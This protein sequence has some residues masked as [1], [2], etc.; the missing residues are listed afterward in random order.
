MAKYTDFPFG[1]YGGVNKKL[2]PDQLPNDT[3]VTMQNFLLRSTGP[4]T[5]PGWSLFTAQKFTDGGATPVTSTILRIAQFFKTDGTIQLVMWTN[6][7]VYKYLSTT[8]LWIPITTASSTTT[9]NGSSSSGQPTLNVTSSASFNVGEEVLINLGN[10]TQEY[11]IIASK[12]AGTLTFTSGWYGSANL[13]FT[14]NNGESVYRVASFAYPVGNPSSV[15]SDVSNG[16]LYFTDLVN[17]VQEW[18]GSATF[19]SDVNN[20]N[21]VEGLPAGQRVRAKYLRVFKNF[22]VLGNL[23]ENGVLITNKIR[24]S[25]FGDFETWA[26]NTDGSGQAGFATFDGTDA[27]NG[28]RQLKDELMIYRDRVTEGQSYVGVPAIFSFRRV[29]GQGEQATGALGNDAIE[30][31]NDFHV[32]LGP[33]NIWIN[34]A[35]S[36]IQLSQEVEDDL[37]TIMNAGNRASSKVFWTKNNDEITIAFP[38]GN[39]S[40]CTK[41]YV[42]NLVFKKWSGPRDLAATALGRF[43]GGNTQTWDTTPGTWDA[44]VGSW[45]SSSLTSNTPLFLMGSNDG[46][47]Y[48]LDSSTTQ[49][50]APIQA[51]YITGVTDLGDDKSI[52]RLLRVFVGCRNDP[53]S[54]LN[55]YVGTLNSP[56]DTVVWNGP[57]TLTLATGVDPF[58]YPNL[59]SRYWQF[60]IDTTNTV[61]IRAI[62]AFLIR[63]QLK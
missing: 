59:T 30:D 33:D 12:G 6:H 19:T 9:T 57:F 22:M 48:Q 2:A 46:F 38:T 42:Y 61:N 29:Q 51:S 11:K 1:T 50:G 53:G 5:A 49:N 52:D 41:A 56:G 7:R 62:E 45:D 17:N 21:T 27:I 58:V 43:V 16:K 39:S 36:F 37:F 23:S 15:D 10:G 31:L 3:A 13:Q 32:I 55:V 54:V 25:R 24:W 47:I 35:I 26:N 14:H 8:T 20:L 63:Q 18:D 4:V 44:Q 34:N 28:L 40:L 60:R